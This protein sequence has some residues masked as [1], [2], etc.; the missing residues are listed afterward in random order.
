ML[1]IYV[2]SPGLYPELGSSAIIDLKP[3]IELVK[4]EKYRRNVKEVY[5]HWDLVI[6]DSGCSDLKQ[7]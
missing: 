2:A 1:G 4:E 6:E 3:L 5:T 7:V